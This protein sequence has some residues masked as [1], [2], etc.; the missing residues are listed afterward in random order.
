MLESSRPILY[1]GMEPLSPRR[2]WLRLLYL[3]IA[4]APLV[5]SV[6]FNL[7]GHSPLRGCPLLHQIGIPCPAWGLTRSFMAL[8]RG[9]WAGAIAFHAF[10]PFLFI[11]FALAAVHLLLEVIRRQRIWAFYLP[12]ITSPKIQIAFF[13][14]LFTYHG[15]RLYRLAMAGDLHIRLLHW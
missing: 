14:T 10:G 3:A 13:L 1:Q 6:V 9:D 12:L 4:C 15:L 2:W 11:G 8:A 7:W 5:G